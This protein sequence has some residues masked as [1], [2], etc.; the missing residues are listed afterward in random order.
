[1]PSPDAAVIALVLGAAALGACLGS[2]G[3][4]M[5]DRGVRGVPR[6]DPPRSECPGCHRILPWR[7]NIPVVSYLLLRGRCRACGWTI[8]LWYLAWEI[9][10]ALLGVAGGV[11][12]VFFA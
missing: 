6:N 9:C 8:P 7:D 3:A 2:F 4:A 10:G 12:V 11:L 1:V 5:W